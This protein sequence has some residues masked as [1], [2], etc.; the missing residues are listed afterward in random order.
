MELHYHRHLYRLR[1]AT[2]CPEG[3]RRLPDGDCVTSV[4]GAAVRYYAHATGEAR[5]KLAK[6]ARA[7]GEAVEASTALDADL[8]VPVPAGR[9]LRPY[10]RAG[11]AYVRDRPNALIADVPRLGKT[12]QAIGAANLSGEALPM[13]VV[14]PATTKVHW[15]RSLVDWRTF[16]GT[17]QMVKGGGQELT[18]DIVV[19]NYEML[20]TYAKQLRQR[21]W[22]W[23]I[24]D[25][26]HYL[27]NR[28]A[29]RTQVALGGDTRQSESGLLGR[30]RLFLTG[31]PIY[32]RPVDLFT[33]CRACDP[34][35]LG[36]KYFDYVRRYCGGWKPG[37]VFDASGASNLE[38]LQVRL[39]RKFMIRREKRDVIGEM[40]T[41][42]D[43][44]VISAG[45]LTG[46][47]DD[48]RNAFLR[49]FTGQHG[50]L[51]EMLE[52]IADQG[53]TPI[54]EDEDGD[55]PLSSQRLRLALAKVPFVV[56]HVQEQ[57]DAGEP[58]VVVFAH[59][60]EV[61][62]AL[63]DAFPG[64]VMLRG[65]MSEKDKQHAI[66]TFQTDPKCRVFVGNIQAAG[67]G[68]TLAAADV[69]V[70]AEISW[71]PSE[72]AQSEERI[73]LPE[74]TA[75]LSIQYVVVADSLDDT[76]VAVLKQRLANMETALNATDLKTRLQ[77]G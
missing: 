11:V 47:V 77:R 72:M 68:I 35:G 32:T 2:T 25:E 34:T 52:G 31:T 8:V 38:E 16:D 9:S 61:V 45:E 48:E 1:G 55:P 74:K 51:E 4:P 18:A 6:L 3:F 29:K 30:R 60:R 10:Q 36:H 71:V 20:Q 40:T 37:D 14:C 75:P 28:D 19:I 21:E 7:V 50:S 76:M 73:W 33:V 58:K 23:I 12:V 59:H 53:D 70:Y 63:R 54:G 17:M 49:L 42:R 46:I 64:S 62:A 13:L 41:Q 27:K 56:A 66:D 67:A 24:F 65:G 26:S 44:V 5:T 57:L 43:T 39:R 15:M 22:A 69:I